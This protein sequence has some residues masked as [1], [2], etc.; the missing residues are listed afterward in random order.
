[1]LKTSD[2]NKST[3]LCGYVDILLF[4]QLETERCAHSSAG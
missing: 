4:L 3:I 1:M 2:K